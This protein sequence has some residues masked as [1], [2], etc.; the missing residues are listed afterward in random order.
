MA[1]TNT[2]ERPVLMKLK[3]CRIHPVT[4]PIRTPKPS[5]NTSCL[6]RS[7]GTL[8]ELSCLR[9]AMQITVMR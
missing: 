9:S 8:S 7:Q 3:C 1:R 6:R 5:P 2:A 4:K